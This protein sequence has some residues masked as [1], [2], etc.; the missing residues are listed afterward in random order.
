MA[1][2]QVRTRQSHRGKP[3]PTIQRKG[4]LTCFTSVN[5][6]FASTTYFRAKTTF[7]ARCLNLPM[8][9]RIYTVRGFILPYA[10]YPGTPGMLL[11]KVINPPFRYLEGAFEPS[12]FPSHFRPATEPT[13]SRNMIAPSRGI[14]T[15]LR[16]ATRA[17]SPRSPS[18]YRIPL[19]S[20][21]PSTIARLQNPNAVTSGATAS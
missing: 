7:A 21:P 10:G 12:F 17:P 9:G 11:E 13:M 1:A 14:T 15:T 19:W 8:K 3:Q 18:R 6:L 16:P 20:A 2:G 4:H 5:V